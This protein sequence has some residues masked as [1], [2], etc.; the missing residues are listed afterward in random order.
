MGFDECSNATVTNDYGTLPTTCNAPITIT[1]TATDNCMNT[2]T[3]TRT[4]TL[5]DS[6]KP[7]IMNSP[8]DLIV[9]L[10]PVK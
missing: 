7:V 1:F 6:T 10:Y 8:S 3:D 9:V 4:I 2:S 5:N